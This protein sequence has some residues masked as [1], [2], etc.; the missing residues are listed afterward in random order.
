MSWAKNVRI[1]FAK[2]PIVKLSPEDEIRYERKTHELLVAEGRSV[3]RAGFPITYIKPTIDPDMANWMRC[4]W[5]YEDD[6]IKAR[7]KALGR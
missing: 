6:D 7:D 4:G 1:D 2:L 3:R 5:R